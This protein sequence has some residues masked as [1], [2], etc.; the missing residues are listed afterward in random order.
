LDFFF[1]SRRLIAAFSLTPFI[2]SAVIVILM[3]LSIK[4]IK[5]V[6]IVFLLYAAIAF[7]AEA[8]LGFPA[9]LVYRFFGW[10]NVVAF[11]GGGIILGLVAMTVVAVIYA[12]FS[13]ATTEEFV[14]ATIAGLSS[15]LAF[16]LIA[17]AHLRT[18]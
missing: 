10:R 11:A 7:V 4:S 13:R 18:A 12:P 9:F 16:R 3:S 6:V 1:M 5:G 8:V 17:G 2:T 15:G 14:F